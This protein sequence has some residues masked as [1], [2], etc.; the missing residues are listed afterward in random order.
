[1]ASLL[2]C[3]GE[4]LN[5]T[6]AVCSVLMTSIRADLLSHIRV[7]LVWLQPNNWNCSRAYIKCLGPV[8]PKMIN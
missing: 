4:L 1:M 6:T 5:E 7:T 3:S 2:F 8:A